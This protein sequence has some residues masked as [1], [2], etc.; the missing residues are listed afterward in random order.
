MLK[1]SHWT[2]D[3]WEAEIMPRQESPNSSWHINFSQNFFCLLLVEYSIE[4]L[5][6]TSLLGGGEMNKKIISL[7]LLV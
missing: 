7:L 5:N 2:I 1:S 4:G 6:C 3:I